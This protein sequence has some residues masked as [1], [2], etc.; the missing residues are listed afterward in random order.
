VTISQGAQVQSAISA[1]LA[2]KYKILHATLQ[3]ECPGCASGQ[4]YCENC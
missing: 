3:L 2:E 1:M 4:V